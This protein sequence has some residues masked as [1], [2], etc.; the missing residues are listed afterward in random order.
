MMKLVMKRNPL[1]TKIP[2]TTVKNVTDALLIKSTV[3]GFITAE[4]EDQ[5]SGPVKMGNITTATDGIVMMKLIVDPENP[6]QVINSFF[7]FSH[8]PK[9]HHLAHKNPE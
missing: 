5:A 8:Q 3:T 4:T 9:M 6:K 2:S 1:L 7:I